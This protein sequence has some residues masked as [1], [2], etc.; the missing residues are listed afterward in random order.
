MSQRIQQKQRQNFMT[1]KNSQRARLL[2]ILNHRPLSAG[3]P[4]PNGKLNSA[5]YIKGSYRGGRNN[6][7]LVTFNDKIV[8]SQ[9]IQ[10]YIVKWYHT[11]LLHP[12]LY[13][14]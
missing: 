12:G 7:K 13:R 5:E 10:R 1:S 2:Y 4:Y 8:I 11:Y 3:I 9:L 14:M 6:V